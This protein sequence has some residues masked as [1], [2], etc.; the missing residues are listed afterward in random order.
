MNSLKF[1]LQLFAE[2]G[3][4]SVDAGNAEVEAN[5]SGAEASE[6][7]ETESTVEST[8]NID[9]GE[10]ADDFNSAGDMFE[11]FIDNMDSEDNTEDAVEN[12]PSEEVIEGEEP[13]ESEQSEIPEVFNTDDL[14]LSDKSS[15]NRNLK[16]FRTLFQN[17]ESEAGDNEGEEEQLEDTDNENDEEKSKFA[18]MDKDEIMDKLYDDPEGFIDELVEERLTTAE[19]RKK[20]EQQE[21]Q[22]KTETLKKHFNEFTQRHPDFEEYSDVMKEL[23]DNPDL[24]LKGNPNA[25]EIS[26]HLARSLKNDEIPTMPTK[27]EMVDQ[28]LNDEETL[29]KVIENEEV[30]NKIVSSYLENLDSNDNIKTIKSKTNK[31]KTV[32]NKKKSFDNFKE[33]EEA[34]FNEM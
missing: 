32:S 15:D 31:G 7:T 27:D 30:K 2:E 33:A 21:K 18:D 3:V 1:D 5:T 25:Y 8:D 9:S 16:T 14:E 28:V 19:M 26:Y 29:S 10:K 13:I 20:Q 24:D 4:E 6:A 12:K 11:S 34:L 17:E 23:I 22:Q